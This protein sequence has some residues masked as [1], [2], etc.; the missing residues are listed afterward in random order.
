MLNF[1]SLYSGSS[2]NCLFVESQNTKILVDCGTSGK[3]VVDG[4]QSIDKNIEDIDA[5]LVTHE[6]SDHIQ[7]LGM[8]SKKY[9]IPV[10]ANFE[11]WQAMR[12]QSD[13]INLENKKIFEN[14]NNFEI[15][16]LLIHP[17]STP[18]DAANPC[19]F[20]IFSGNKKISIATDLGHME[21]TIF[22]NLKGS[23]FVLLEA[24]YDPEILKV[25][26]YPFMLKQRISGPHGHLSN[27]TSGK[28]V[29]KLMNYDLKEVMLGHLSKENNFP[30]LAYQTV[31]EELMSQNK[32]MGTI[33]LSVASRVNPS[34][35][36]NI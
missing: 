16:N 13:K 28:T 31:A 26:R 27:S 30:E 2:G 25:S 1:C 36:V 32:D 15:G 3:K 34:K 33:S 8:I 6:H 21:D 12:E 35:I 11:T 14:D 7:S 18:H 10:Y 23:S 20:N 17:F 9:N 24:N 29:A 22:E 5:I 19:G 4:L